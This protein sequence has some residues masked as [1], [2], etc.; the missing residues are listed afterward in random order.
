MSYYLAKQINEAFPEIIHDSA[1]NSG[2]WTDGESLSLG[3]HGEIDVT[4]KLHDFADELMSKIML[5]IAINH[6]NTDNPQ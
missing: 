4:D 3:E 2:F 1:V 6:F 5:M